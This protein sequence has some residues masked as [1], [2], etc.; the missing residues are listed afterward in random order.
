V[1]R[2]SM[3]NPWEIGR[4]HPKIATN[5]AQ[6]LFIHYGGQ[7]ESDRGATNHLLGFRNCRGDRLSNVLF[8]E[9]PA[10]LDRA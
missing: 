10:T 5:I 7:F 3:L 6:W 2:S 8:C 9:L 4:C 1:P